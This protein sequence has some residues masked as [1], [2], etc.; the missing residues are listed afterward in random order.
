MN[1]LLVSNYPSDTGYAWWLMEHFWVIISQIASRKGRKTYLAY[2]KIKS[3]DRAIIESGIQPVEMPVNYFSVKNIYR[4]ASFIV[5]NKIQIVYLTDRPYFSFLYLFLRFLG[6]KKLIIHDHTPGDRP[7]VTGLKGY[8]KSL[9]NK[10]PCITADI[11]INVSPL[12]RDR[13]ILNGRVPREKCYVVQNGISID[14]EIKNRNALRKNIGVR[15]DDIVAITTGRL[16][17][18]KRVGFIIEAIDIFLKGNLK[19]T[20]NIYFIIAG[21][22]PDR[23]M[24][25]Q[26][27]HEK[28]ISSRVWLLGH[29]DDI[30]DLLAISDFAI[31][32]S[33]GEGFSLS[34]CEYMASGLPVILPDTPSVSQAIN[35]K[36]TGLVY[37]SKCVSCLAECI[38]ILCTD[39]EL[40]SRLGESARNVALEKYNLDRTTSEFVNIFKSIV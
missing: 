10:I 26:M 33:K 4:L 18:Y 17:P 34:I 38:H 7:P 22:G 5:K 30:S 40:R 8:L 9:R 32:A 25:E 12:M 24:L 37:P 14:N 1:V 6:V 35:D 13:S 15:C 27:I 29:R 16:H 39:D 11:I 23:E 20:R 28:G 19:L 21:D 31:H 3:I 2:P 36:E